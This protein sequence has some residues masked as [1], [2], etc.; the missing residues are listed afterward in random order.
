[1]EK[2]N[3]ESPLLLS[4]EKGGG[5]VLAEVKKQLWLAGPLI[6][7]SLLQ[8]I[9]QVISVMF[10][11][12]LGELALSGASMATSFA[13]VTG[14]GLLVCALISFSFLSFTHFYMGASRTDHLIGICKAILYF[15]T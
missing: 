6:A 8:M 14:F 7:T 5:D 11:G 9:L 3:V 15:C 12:H 1:M 10:V 4:Y 2:P 13:G